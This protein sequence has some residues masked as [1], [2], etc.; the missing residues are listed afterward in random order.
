[1]IVESPAD[2]PVTN[3]VLLTVAT[4]AALL[5]HVPPAVAMLS[6]VV[7][8]IQTPLLPVITAT[9]GNGLTVTASV[10]VLVQPLALGAVV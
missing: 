9:V 5:L 4:P 3:P 8:P 1:M 7:L 2:T 10:A 6:W